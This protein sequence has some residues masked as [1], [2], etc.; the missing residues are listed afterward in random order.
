MPPPGVVAPACRPG[1]GYGTALAAGAAVAG[2][3]MKNLLLPAEVARLLAAAEAVSND[4]IAPRAAAVDRDGRWPAEG[5]RALCD[6]GLGG[7]TVPR[8]LGGHGQGLLGVAVLTEAIGRACASTAMCFGMH[9]V[10]S[11]VIAAK[12]TRDQEERY[13]RGIAE[14]RHLSS[15]ALSEAGTGANF[16]LAET[17]LEQDGEQFRVYGTKQ[18]VTSGGEADSYVI[19]TLASDRA[20]SGDFSC[21]LLDGD[22]PGLQWGPP[23]Q[24]MGMRG[25]SSR[26]LHLEGAR[27]PQRNLLGAE[28][29]QTWYVFEIIA[30]F[31]LVAMAGTYIGVARAALELTLQHVKS[32]RFT[33]SGQPVS[34]FDTVQHRVGVL[35]AAVERA[36]LMLYRAAE[37]GDQSHPEA[38]PFI[39]ASKAE[40]ADAA[41]FATSE[42]MTLGGGSAYRDDGTLARLL[43]DA[44]AAH[45]MSPT[46]DM[47]RLW[48]G[49]QQLGMSL[50]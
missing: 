38:L 19:S 27:V 20:A 29:D 31:F 3:T 47:L 30:P 50:F 46:T 48:S 8:Q 6:A 14:G 35:W 36:A 5:L 39:L 32:R 12:A 26:T 25:N 18:F 49:R 45:V 40:A 7:V 33:H 2:A 11:T 21:L 1:L 4:V 34:A 9:L 41:V 44:R 42:A 43:R 10:A 28:G 23:W 17:R 22:T 24:G 15:L 37:L 16:Y 13:L